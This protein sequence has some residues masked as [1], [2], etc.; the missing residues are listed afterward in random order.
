MKG[1]DR[2]RRGKSFSGVLSYA[3]KPAPHRLQVP[4]VI[5]GNAPGITVDELVTEFRRTSQLRPE[6]AKPVWHNSLRLPRGETLSHQKWTEIADDYMKKMGFSSTHMRTCILHDDAA[7]Q[8]IHIIAS[9]IDIF[10]GKLYLG[11]N[12]NLI[13]TRII[14]E[15]EREHQLIRTKGPAPLNRL[16]PARRKKISRNEQQ[17]EERQDKPSPR[18]VLQAALER[19]LTNRPGMAEFVQQLAAQNIRATPNIASTGRMNGF[20]F[21]C[22]GI[23]FKASQLGKGYSWASLQARIDYQPERDNPYLLTLKNPVVSEAFKTVAVELPSEVEIPDIVVAITENQSLNSPLQAAS[24]LCPEPAIS[25]DT[26]HTQALTEEISPASATGNHKE[27]HYQGHLKLRWLSWIPYL[28]VLRDLLKGLGYSLLR[29]TMAG[30]SITGVHRLPENGG[31]TKI[32]TTAP[33][34]KFINKSI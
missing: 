1:M 28:D 5:G 16:V 15:L 20:S 9:R 31:A 13:S 11:R 21:E 14:Q 2:I 33:S 7:G 34:P 25:V 24:D 23:A 27:N 19:T 4:V 3:L 10:G 32:K 6:V 17:M 29:T 22:E 8:H 26:G 12:E 30:K 18:S